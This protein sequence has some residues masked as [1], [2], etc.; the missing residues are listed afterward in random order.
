MPLA[1]TA[2]YRAAR[3]LGAAKEEIQRCAGKQFDPWIVEVFMKMPDHIWQDLAE[4]VAS[5]N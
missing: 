4:Q 2:P 5:A 1:V 3:V